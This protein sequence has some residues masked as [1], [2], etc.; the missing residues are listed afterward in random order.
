MQDYNINIIVVFLGACDSF[1]AKS[2]KRYPGQWEE[3]PHLAHHNLQLAAK[4]STHTYTLVFKMMA[5]RDGRLP[6]ASARGRLELKML[7]RGEKEGTRVLQSKRGV[8]NETHLMFN[9]RGETP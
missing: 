3:A 6:E 2:M 7:K 9:Q 5:Q 4:I 1:G 8:Y